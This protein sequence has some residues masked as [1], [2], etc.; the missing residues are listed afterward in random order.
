[1]L[2]SLE[3]PLGGDEAIKMMMLPTDQLVVV[4]AHHIQAIGT[5]ATLVTNRTSQRRAL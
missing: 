1:M 3:P 5:A 4:S 2:A